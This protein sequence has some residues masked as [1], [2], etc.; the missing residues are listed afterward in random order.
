MSTVTMSEKGHD[1]CRTNSDS[2]I[3]G[4]LLAMIPS[5][6]LRQFGSL[7]LL[8]TLPHYSLS[9]LRNLYDHAT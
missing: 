8:Q 1:V 2:Y 3:V 7:T 6:T 4:N 5:G 9:I